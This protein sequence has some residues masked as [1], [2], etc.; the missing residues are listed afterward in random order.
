MVRQKYPPDAWGVFLEVAYAGASSPL[1]CVS[2][3]Q[4]FSADYPAGTGPY[5]LH[6]CAGPAAQCMGNAG[7][8]Q[9]LHAVHLRVR[10]A[11]SVKEAW[12]VDL[13]ALRKKLTDES[14]EDESDGAKENTKEKVR[15]LRERLLLHK[16]DD[17][18][19]SAAD[20]LNFAV[21]AESIKTKK[22]KRE[23]SPKRD[24]SR[25]RRKK[26]RSRGQ[27]GSTS[28]ESSPS[29]RGLFRVGSSLSGG[30]RSRIQRIADDQPQESC[31][32]K[33]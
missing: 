18:K 5:V 12:A 25:R 1:Q 29:E 27:D 3:R 8:K 20:R 13:K 2:L 11:S 16:L 22:K 7:H 28:T 17:P 4:G 15:E 10:R 19:L 6:W 21:A 24:R 32:A 30:S 9:A 33:R 26:R 31:T 23:K 14:D